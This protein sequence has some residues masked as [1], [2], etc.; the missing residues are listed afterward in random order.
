MGIIENIL[1]YLSNPFET[2]TS[3]ELYQHVI[4][5]NPQNEGAVQYLIDHIPTDELKDIRNLMRTEG[6]NWWIACHH[7]FGMN[8]RNILREGGYHWNA[9]QLDNLW[10]E[11]VEAAVTKKFDNENY[12][13]DSVDG[14]MIIRDEDGSIQG[15][16]FPDNFVK[17]ETEEEKIQ[18]QKQDTHFILK[19]IKN[20]VTNNS[21]TFRCYTCGKKDSP[22]FIGKDREKYCREHILPENRGVS[23]G[24]QKI[25]KKI[26]LP[27]FRC[28]NPACNR[29]I[30]QKDIIQCGPCGNF[31][32]IYCWEDHRWCHG[33]SPSVGIGYCSDGSWYGYDGSE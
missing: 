10:V 23:K 27:T 20:P 13:V 3:P 11:L 17:K 29:K 8:V 30:Y 9:Q 33:K 32:C 28:K 7:G 1:K 18:P 14:E 2:Q 15:R 26:S 16:Y 19:Q 22:L 12:V 24:S 25:I 5:I 6:P 21:K 4:Y 31:F